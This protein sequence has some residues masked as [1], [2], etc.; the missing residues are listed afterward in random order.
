MA[1]Y[2]GK[3]LNEGMKMDCL[4][5]DVFTEAFNEICTEALKGEAVEYEHFFRNSSGNTA[6]FRFTISPIVDTLGNVIGLTMAGTN[7][8]DQKLREKTIRNQGESLSA[9]AQL[10]SHQVRQPVTSIM[11]LMQL[12]KE[13]N[14]ELRREYLLSL[15][16]A[17]KQLDTVIQTIVK[18]SR[19]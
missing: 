18:Q 2:M 9:I 11:G 6:W 12:I 7:I 16:Q 17:T 19:S 13:D 4:L 3:Q 15:E 14:Y 1:L 5:D 8:T 10:Q